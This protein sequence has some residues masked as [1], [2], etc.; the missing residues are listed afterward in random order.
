MAEGRKIEEF[1]NHPGAP[2]DHTGDFWGFADATG[3]STG[4]AQVGDAD[5]PWPAMV[6]LGVDDGTLLSD[7]ARAFG[8]ALIAAADRAD[9]KNRIAFS[10]PPLLGGGDD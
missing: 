7:D 5:P 6:E 2:L 8:L 9:E 3:M 1:Q 4:Y 10:S